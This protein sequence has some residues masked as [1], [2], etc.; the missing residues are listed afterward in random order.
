M[1]KKIFF[2]VVLWKSIFYG[3]MIRYNFHHKKIFLFGKN[4]CFHDLLLL[5]WW[6]DRVM[7]VVIDIKTLYGNLKY[8]FFNRFAPNRMHLMVDSR[9]YQKSS[10]YRLFT[11]CIPQSHRYFTNDPPKNSSI[12]IYWESNISFFPVRKAFLFVYFLEIHFS[13]YFRAFFA[14]ENIWL[15]SIN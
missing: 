15:V 10:I 8:K 3:C 13:Y 4:M 12:R 14:N 2:F 6:E 1:Y 11:S 7:S 9:H 5:I